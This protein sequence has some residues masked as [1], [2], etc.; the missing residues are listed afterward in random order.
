M[1]MTILLLEV[2]LAMVGFATAWD[3][4][5]QM[6]YAYQKTAS[7]QTGQPLSWLS[8]AQSDADFAS[9][10][11]YG[12]DQASVAN[13]PEIINGKLQ[14]ANSNTSLPYTNDSLS[15]SQDGS[16][17]GTTAAPDLESPDGI[18]ASGQAADPE[19]ISQFYGSNTSVTDGVYALF[20][21]KE[22]VDLS[23][24]DILGT[25]AIGGNRPEASGQGETQYSS[26][27][28]T[29]ASSFIVK[30]NLG[31]PTTAGFDQIQAEG[32]IPTTS[33]GDSTYAGIGSVGANQVE[34]QMADS[35]G[36]QM[37]SQWSSSNPTFN[38]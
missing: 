6:Q 21:Q 22:G 24:A 9:G 12:A 18:T 4:N 33:G 3:I 38:I 5:D 17:T 2:V 30:A 32:S 11:A 27:I 29:G 23:I 25:V 37:T 7:Q 35:T 19:S 10:T 36:F 13:G 31:E 26:A 14:T 8:L 1:K 15:Q 28:E 16:T 34:T 20:L